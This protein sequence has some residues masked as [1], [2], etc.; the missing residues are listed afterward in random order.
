MTKPTTDQHDPGPHPN[1]SAGRKRADYYRKW[2]KMVAQRRRSEMPWLRNVQNLIAENQEC[3]PWTKLAIAIVHQAIVDARH[4]LCTA[5]CAEL[6]TLA[7]VLGVKLDEGRIRHLVRNSPAGV[8][9][10]QPAGLG[11]QQ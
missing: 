10:P 3:D 9:Q 7:E 8:V 4:G 5:T 1:S 2:R 6:A 11:W